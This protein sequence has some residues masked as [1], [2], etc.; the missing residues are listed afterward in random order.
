[1]LFMYQIVKENGYKY[2]LR[3][4]QLH[5]PSLLF[6]D[7]IYVFIILLSAVFLTQNHYYFQISS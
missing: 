1:M 6:F 4:D 7:L 5:F 2:L 3:Q